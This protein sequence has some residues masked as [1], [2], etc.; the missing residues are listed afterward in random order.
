[1]NA[2]PFFF[3]FAICAV[4]FLCG[5]VIGALS[6]RILNFFGAGMVGARRRGHARYRL[7]DNSRYRASLFPHTERGRPCEAS[8]DQ[9]RLAPE[10]EAQ[11]SP[12]GPGSPPNKPLM[13][14]AR[15]SDGVPTQA[16]REP[17]A[18]RFFS[19]GG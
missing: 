14:K 1:M 4:I 6:D 16:D 13:R 5:V 9:R 2:G 15:G 18:N 10:R 19:S 17:G 11:I 3:F 12:G 8:P 7:L